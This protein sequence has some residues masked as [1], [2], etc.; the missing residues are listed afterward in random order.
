MALS[1]LVGRVRDTDQQE[2]SLILSL[3][4]QESIPQVK[5]RLLTVVRPKVSK[6]AVENSSPCA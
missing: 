3:P 5:T 2:S 1:R 4:L 6:V